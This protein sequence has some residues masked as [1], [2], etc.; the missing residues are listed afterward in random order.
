MPEPKGFDDFLA[1]GGRILHSSQ[2]LLLDQ[3]AGKRVVVLGYGKSACDAEVEVAR[4]AN[5]TTLVAKGLFWKLP[6]Y[7]GGLLHIG[8]ALFP[9]VRPWRKQ[10]VMNTVGAPIRRLLF[11]SLAAVTALQLGLRKLALAPE[12]GFE[13]IAQ[14]TI[15]L[16]TPGLY[17]AID[18]GQVDFHRGVVHLL[19][20]GFASSLFCPLTAEVSALWLVA[21]LSEQKLFSLPTEEEQRRLAEH[22]ARWL[23]QRNNGKHAKATNIVPFSMSFIDELLGDLGVGIGWW[24]YFK[25][26]ILPINPSAYKKILQQVLQRKAALEVAVTAG[27]GSD[28]GRR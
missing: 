5:S 12:I 18:K 15:S 19:F 10:R 13:T 21:Q 7:V 8:E 24:D 9:W 14:S 17:D 23:E 6:T 3:V 27:L 25:E 26:W 16:A 11:S 4:V 2:L 1:A 20:I 22:E 28:L